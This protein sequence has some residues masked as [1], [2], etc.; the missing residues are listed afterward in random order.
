MVFKTFLQNQ[1]YAKES[2]CS[3]GKA[4][5]EYLGHLISEQ[6]VETNPDKIECMKQWPIPNSLKFLRGFLGLTSYYRRFSKYYWQISQPLTDLLKKDNFVWSKEAE[7]AFNHMKVA[8]CKA[9]TL[10]MP[11]FQMEF[12]IECDVA[13]GGIGAVLSQGGRPIAYLSKSLSPK[14]LGMSI[15]E[16]EMMTVVYAV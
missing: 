9:P 5:I 7:N 8:M 2:K 14:H 4:Q 12:R 6:G 3:F 1:L 16:K 11:N 13:G 15:Y 10:A